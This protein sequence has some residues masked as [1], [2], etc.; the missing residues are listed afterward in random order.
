MK[1][2]SPLGNELRSYPMT[3]QH[4]GVGREPR[5]GAPAT[6]GVISN[7]KE[8]ARPSSQV[9]PGQTQE[10]VAHLWPHDAPYDVLGHG[11]ALFGWKDQFE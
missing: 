2:T 9:N 6:N 7:A 8:M 1:R 10:R 5:A 3:T 4:H 11:S